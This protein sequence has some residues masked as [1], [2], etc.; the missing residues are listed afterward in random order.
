MQNNSPKIYSIVCIL[1]VLLEFFGLKLGTI[2]QSNW[3]Y[4]QF[5]ILVILV[6][7]CI[8]TKPL[9]SKL[10]IASACFV[11]LSCLYSCFY[12]GQALYIVIVH[13]YK[14][15]SI[16]FFFYLMKNQLS[17]RDTETILITVAI[18]CC[19]CYI[20][21]WLIYP[22]ILF[23]GADRANETNYRVRIPGSLCCY[24]L[25]YYGV[26]IFL[27]GRRK[28]G[29]VYALL[30]FLPILIMGFRSLLSISF[31]SF[32]LMI[33]FVMKKTGR[34]IFYSVLGALFVFMMM[35][36]SL[37]QSK[38]DEMERRTK[39]GQTFDNENYIRWR[40]LDY[41][42]NEQ[43][44]HPVERIVGGG[45]PKDLQSHYAKTIYGYAYAH[46]L[47]WDDLGLV[48]L[49]FIIGIPAVVLFISLYLICIWRCKEPQLQYLRFTLIV[50]LLG[51]LFTT[52]ELYREGNI[53]MLTLLLYLEYK[54]HQE[55]RLR[56]GILLKRLLC[57]I[58]QKRNQRCYRE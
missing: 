12:N 29:T 24:C 14:F 18:I 57:Y 4:P 47:Y 27:L 3:D 13:S 38:L 55:K 21:Q 43:F 36:T 56:N 32:F 26:N 8:K 42:W 17:A 30:G 28:N 40:E 2:T 15:F 22:T 45:V 52:A 53:L 1:L 44:K 5:I 11:C 46:H 41:Y 7:S 39:S 58:R 51:S 34:T 35:Q 23:Q 16:F 9:Y 48:G 6:W 50:V 25:F 49:S 20:L 54:Y 31:I 37:V 10:I 33:P 19:C